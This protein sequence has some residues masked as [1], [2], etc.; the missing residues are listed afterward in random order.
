M[1]KIVWHFVRKKRGVS[2]QELGLLKIPFAESRQV[3]I[4]ERCEDPGITRSIAFLGAAFE[5]AY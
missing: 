1:T 3:G 5:F 4:A 2:A